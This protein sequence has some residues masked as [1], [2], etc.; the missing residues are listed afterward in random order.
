MFC[1]RE[2]FISYHPFLKSFFL[3]TDLEM[4]SGSHVPVPLWEAC[5]V[6][7]ISTEGGHHQGISWFKNY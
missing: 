3:I 7:E 5:T 4:D 2:S 6:L 1:P